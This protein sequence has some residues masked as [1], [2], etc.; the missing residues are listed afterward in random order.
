MDLGKYLWI[1]HQQHVFMNP[2]SGAKADE[3]IELLDLPAES[4]ILDMACGKAEFLL[5]TVERW[6]ARGTGV[7][8]SPRWVEESRTT[9]AARGLGDRVEIVEED[10]RRYKCQESFYAVSCLG[11]N[12]WGDGTHSALSVFAKPG[13][14]IAVGEP[15]WAK[16]P[17]AEH[18]SAAELT[19]A[20]MTTHVGNIEN[21]ISRGFT[22]LHAVV[23][24]QD[25]WD[26]YEGYH[27]YSAEKYASENP[28]DPDVPELLQGIRG[29]NLC[30]SDKMDYDD[31]YLRW[32]REEVGWAVYLFRKP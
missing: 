5:R 3:I 11:A 31:I 28:E 13:G 29:G 9:A 20:S 19:R 18:L 24:S 14:I 17:S 22:F 6:G 7:E 26:R 15:F 1:I 27:R 30:C 21:G 12:L 8:L 32:G 10:G 16:E 4:R 2:L 25:D 23:S